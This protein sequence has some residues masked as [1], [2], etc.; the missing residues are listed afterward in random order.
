MV[1]S[2]YG[3]WLCEMCFKIARTGARQDIVPECHAWK[4]RLGSDPED[5]YVCVL[6][7]SLETIAGPWKN[8]FAT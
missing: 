7:D 2:E 6:M 4:D 3:R 1:S 5:G 8:K